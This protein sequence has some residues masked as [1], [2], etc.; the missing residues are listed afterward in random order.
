[1]RIGPRPR[2]SAMMSPQGIH[3][4][5]VRRAK[6]APQLTRYA[7]KVSSIGDPD[8]GTRTLADIV[9]GEG[10]RGGKLSLSV[11][12]FGTYHHILTLP[13]APR[14]ILLPIMRRELRRFYPDLFQGE[15]DEPVIDY[16]EIDSSGRGG[17]GQMREY[18]VAA[19][20]RTLVD[21][22]CGT[23]QARGIQIEHWTILPQALQRLYDVFAAEPEPSALLLMVPKA[24]LLGFFQSGELRFF[25]EPLLS[26][27]WQ[28]ETQ[29]AA[30]IE[31]VER[32]SLFLR[33]QFRGAF[34]DRLLLAV[35]PE[36]AERNAATLRERLQLQVRAFS[37]YHDSP[38]ALAALGAALDADAGHRLNLL[39][40][41]YRPASPSE[42]WSRALGVASAAVVI[43]AAVW[44]GWGAVQLERR[45]EQR[46]A[47]LQAELSAR[48][49]VY[50]EVEP[51]VR[52]RQDHVQRAQIL[53]VLATE[54][55]RL[56]GILWPL[57]GT[58]SAIRLR[59]FDLTRGPTGW[60]GRLSGTALGYTSAAASNA[61]DGIFRDIAA[62]LPPGS[63]TLDN[64]DYVEPTYDPAD[65][66]GE[67]YVGP[68]I[69][70]NFQL[71]FIVPI[72]EDSGT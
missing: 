42:V 62:E 29:M 63:V 6:G 26:A 16:V 33:Q 51:I 53:S 41:E 5:Q 40:A 72:L 11:I 69:A 3:V 49:D 2:F 59:Q 32:G 43:A 47:A 14:E 28:A 25:S 1:M 9:E 13:A 18:L 34:V 39:P 57:Q 68:S 54:R 10:G 71:S 17:A 44:W 24:P 60:Q 37:P 56:P 52:E 27:E 15:A 35:D 21:R 58:S 22:V 23:L 48:G 64:L 8:T 38:G 4:V 45:A 65:D 31:Q 55:D 61:I 70:I 30:V 7:G 12:G 20:P 46:V 19:V 67:S 66:L 36:D 50:A